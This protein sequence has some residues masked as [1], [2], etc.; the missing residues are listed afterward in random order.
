MASP[1]SR[2]E[3]SL[4]ALTSTGCAQLCAINTWLAVPDQHTVRGWLRTTGLFVNEM[5]LHVLTTT[6]LFAAVW[7]S[8]DLLR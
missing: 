7:L 4:T 3:A 2:W 5:S 1:S 8:Y 6:V